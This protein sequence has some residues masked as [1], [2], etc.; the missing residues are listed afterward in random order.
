MF[1]RTL[2]AGLAFSITA[3]AATVGTLTLPAD[4]DGGAVTL[5]YPTAAAG[6]PETRGDL[7]LLIAP[8]AVPAAG[9][10]RLI[11]ISHGSGGGPWVHSTLAQ[12]LVDAGFTVA[13][14]LHRGDNWTD[15]A[16]PG[17]ESWKLRP[18]E[19][20]HAID[21]VA[22]DPRF[23]GLKLDR[24]G[25]FG[26][27]AGGHTMLT[28]AGGAWSPERFRQHCEQHLADDFNACVGLATG[29]TGG[30]LDGF[31]LWLARRV[32]SW[33]FGGDDAPQTHTDPRLAAIVAGVPAAADF[34]LA[35]LVHPRVPLG[36]IT[37]RDDRWLSPRFHSEPVLAACQGCERLADLPGAGH[38]ALLAPPPPADRLGHLECSL[39]CDP[40]GFDRPATTA[41]WVGRTVAFFQRHLLSA[42]TAEPELAQQALPVK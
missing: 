20:S 38:G 10:G 32:L 42:G 7:R 11:A 2:L 25:G 21:R 13:V 37:A 16:H 39:L 12:A 36:L 40:P 23:A 31:K 3:H 4:E 41:L 9:N 14:P 1:F 35:S 28:L 6:Q 8:D 34:D 24:V 5:F 30:W 33:K 26:M 27:S 17:P 18:A 22:A 15:P 19:I 29:L